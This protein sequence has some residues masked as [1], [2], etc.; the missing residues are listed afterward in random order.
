MLEYAPASGEQFPP[1]VPP[2]G[3]D[4]AGVV[5]VVGAAGAAGVVV[6]VLPTLLKAY[7]VRDISFHNLTF[8]HTSGGDCHT[9]GTGRFPACDSDE[10]ARG[11]CMCIGLR[12]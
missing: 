9:S 4:E 6:P 10:G 11:M 2:L 3:G 12:L 1:F 8:E 5:G 7:T